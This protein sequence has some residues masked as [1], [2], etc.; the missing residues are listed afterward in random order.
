MG[1]SSEATLTHEQ[2]LDRA[3][4]LLELDPAGVAIW[5]WQTW[6]RELA[7]DVRT[8]A[9]E[10]E[11]LQQFVQD[12]QLLRNLTAERD[13]LAAELEQQCQINRE[14][15]TRYEEAMKAARIAQLDWEGAQAKLDT[16]RLEL[17][18]EQELLQEENE[19]LAEEHAVMTLQVEHHRKI[20]QSMLPNP[21]NGA[22][23]SPS[24]STP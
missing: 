13:R 12:P 18:A 1:Q 4:R 11:Q 10:N 19:A 8:L 23:D 5:M 22:G 20:I 2:E 3:N 6:A 24:Q 14:E 21:P 15:T 7:L 17:E 9:A 16:V